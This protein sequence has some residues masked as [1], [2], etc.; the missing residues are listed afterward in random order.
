[1][2]NHLFTYFLMLFSVLC[3]HSSSESPHPL[4]LAV[5]GI[6]SVLAGTGTVVALG[7]ALHAAVEALRTPGRASVAEVVTAV[8]ATA[9]LVLL[10]WVC[11]GLLISVLAALPGRIGRVATRTGDRVVTAAVRRWAAILLGVCVASACAPGGAVAEPATMT[12]PVRTATPSDG[13]VAP[14][15]PA[16]V[17]G[18]DPTPD[19]APAPAWTPT[20]VRSHPPVTLTAPRQLPAEQDRR[21]VTVR[22][23]DTLWHLAAAHLPEA[24]TDAEIAAEWQ[25]WY[26]LN[27]TVIG[28]DPD[29]ILPGQRLMIP[30]PSADLA[31]TTTETAR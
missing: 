3:M 23:G 30:S 10:A 24:A 6:S 2:D 4:R 12:Q 22:R 26:S 9:A 8:S 1:M 28:A 17:W 7:S 21:E 13:L 15:A 27:R 14:G 31:T 20:P 19:P 29:L 16:P 5:V 18:A 25:R 11:V